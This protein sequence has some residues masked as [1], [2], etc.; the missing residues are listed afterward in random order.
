MVCVLFVMLGHVWPLL[1]KFKGGKGIAT[2]FG[3][4]LAL[5]PLLAL[6]ELAIVAAVTLVTKRMSAGSIAGLVLLPVICIFRQP[7]EFVVISIILAV[8]MLIKHKANI[9]RI[10]HG[11]EPKLSILDKKSSDS[12]RS[13]KEEEQ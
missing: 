13:D 10:I 7:A 11:E 9:I 1:L 5:D 12:E 4:L 8:I 3:A 2:S 6:I